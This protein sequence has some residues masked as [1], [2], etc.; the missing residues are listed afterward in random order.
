MARGWL[1]CPF[2]SLQMPL[3]GFG[4]KPNPYLPIQVTLM[5]SRGLRMPQIA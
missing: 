5:P 4:P 3:E 1:P 2:R